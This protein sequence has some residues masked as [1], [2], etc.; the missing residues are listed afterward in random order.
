[1]LFRTGRLISQC[2]PSFPPC[3]VTFS[4]FISR[5]LQILLIDARLPLIEKFSTSIDP[6]CTSKRDKRPK[7]QGNIPRVQPVGRDCLPSD[8]NMDIDTRCIN[9]LDP[10]WHRTPDKYYPIVNN[11]EFG[12]GKIVFSDAQWSKSGDCFVVTQQDGCVSIFTPNGKKINSYYE[13]T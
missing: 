7:P 9:N 5:S 13:Q 3:T 11:L 2:L 10:P 8:A 4:A 6:I 12:G 1:M